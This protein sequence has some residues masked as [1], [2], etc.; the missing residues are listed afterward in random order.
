[1]LGSRYN[2]PYAAM[3]YQ[4]QEALRHR[5]GSATM[6]TD[7]DW[8]G[9]SPRTIDGETFW[10]LAVTTRWLEREDELAVVLAESLPAREDGDTVVISEKVAVLLTGRTV[11]L[12]RFAAKKPARM[13]VRFVQPRQGSR[14]LSVPEKMQYVIDAVGLP[15][16]LAAALA[17]ALTRP[18]GWHGV[19]YR[20]AGSVARDLDGGRPP[21]EDVLFPPLEP[22]VALALVAELEETLGTGTAIVDVNDY[23]GSIR[24]TS[25]SALD[26]DRLLGAL[27]D[28]PLGQSASSRPFGVVRRVPT[29]AAD[30]RRA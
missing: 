26:A 27:G 23:G 12:S 24:A 17:S 14:G 1:M 30:K 25:S 13:L 2:G 15:R 8:G 19:F 28:N 6:T 29:N 4:E 21:Y 11:P 3:T 20:V 7:D 18:F 9:W 22:Q 16:V 10:R 5:K